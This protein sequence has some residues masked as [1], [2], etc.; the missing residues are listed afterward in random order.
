M[1]TTKKILT[2]FGAT[3]IQGGSVA[4]S[5]L[6][7]PLTKSLYTVRAVTRDISKPAA[8]ALLALGAEL[9]TVPIPIPSP[10]PMYAWNYY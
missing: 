8:Q 10:N 2:I 6:I 4:R 9:A 5:I 7:D 1:S 3:G